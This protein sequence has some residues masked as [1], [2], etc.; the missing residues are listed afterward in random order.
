MLG[1]YKTT[2]L[3]GTL[4]ALSAGCGTTQIVASDPQAL[5][6]VDGV[7][8]GRGM[9]SV[10]KTGFPGSVTVQAKTDDGRSAFQ[11]MSRSF[12]WPAG[13]FGFFTYGV[14]FFACWQY[15]DVVYLVL[16][17]PPRWD[18]PGGWNA[19]GGP[20]WYQDPWIMP[21]PGWRPARQVDEKAPSPPA[22]P[23]MPRSNPTVPPPAPP[24]P[25]R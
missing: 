22:T 3:L 2:L 25:P 5:I 17:S 4:A 21:P 1:F 14:C 7:P 12:G 11:P 19:A 13:L 24:P 20:G 15:P 10:Q 18:A 23:G 8:S 16:P 9:A 6:T